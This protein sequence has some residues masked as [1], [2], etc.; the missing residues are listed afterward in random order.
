MHMKRYRTA[1]SYNRD[2]YT[3]HHISNNEWVSGK[4]LP[5]TEEI[6]IYLET[7]NN[8][9]INDNRM[10]IGAMKELIHHSKSNS[11]IKRHKVYTI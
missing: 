2:T 1:S 5:T 10:I 4:R 3:H 7:H 9:S 11:S 8:R 6:R